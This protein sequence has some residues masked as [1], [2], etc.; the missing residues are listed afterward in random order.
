MNNGRNLARHVGVEVSVPRPLINRSARL[1]TLEEDIQ[2]TQRSGDILFFSYQAQPVFP[3]QECYAMMVWVG[4]HGNNC[5]HITNDTYLKWRI[6]AD[7]SIPV[8][9][10]IQILSYRSVQRAIQGFNTAKR[11]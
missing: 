11:K 5:R 10:Q 6:Y 3:S 8:E 4:I 1:K 9:G 2:Y 7:D